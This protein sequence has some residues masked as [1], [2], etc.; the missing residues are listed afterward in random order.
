LD[1][2]YSIA[3]KQDGK[4]ICRASGNL[5]ETSSPVRTLMGDASEGKQ[6]GFVVFAYAGRLKRGEKKNKGRLV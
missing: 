6:G 3:A 4:C 5:P 1:L 2:V